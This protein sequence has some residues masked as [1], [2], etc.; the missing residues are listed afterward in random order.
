MDVFMLDIIKK[1][2]RDKKVWI[3][4]L[5]VLTAIGVSISPELQEAIAVAGV[6][7]TDAILLATA[8]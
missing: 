7:L 3:G 4:A 5:S 2:A 6:A 8:E 1:Y